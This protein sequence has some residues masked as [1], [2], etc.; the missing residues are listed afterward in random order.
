MTPRR[1]HWIGIL[2]IVVGGLFNF[3]IP[4]FFLEPRSSVGTAEHLLE[5][6]LCANVIA[7]LV[8]ALGIFR[9]MRWGWIIGIV[10]C[11]FSASLWVAQETIGLPGLPQQ[12][13][14]PSRIASL[15]VE[16]V[17]VVTALN[18]VFAARRAENDIHATL[19]Q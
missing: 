16:G 4:H 12:W 8:A 5:L 13:L 1:S 11:V 19:E 3:H 18:Q 17:F 7:S 10:V 6:V 15:A 2:L 14:E 9:S